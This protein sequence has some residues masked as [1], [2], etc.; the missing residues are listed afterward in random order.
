MSYFLL[1]LLICSWC[2][3]YLDRLPF[4]IFEKIPS[5][6]SL[7]VFLYRLNEIL[8]LVYL[9]YVGFAIA[10]AIFCSYIRKP[11]IDLD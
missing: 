5:M 9:N 1:V 4:P 3:L 6:I 2:L 11:V 10:H 8:F 7:K